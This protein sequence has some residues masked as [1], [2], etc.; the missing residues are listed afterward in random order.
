MI[1][2]DKLQKLTIKGQKDAEKKAAKEEIADKNYDKKLLEKLEQWLEY[3]ITEFAKGGKHKAILPISLG[4]TC[5]W[6]FK[7]LNVI[8]EVKKILNKFNFSDSDYSIDNPESECPV[9]I[10][11]W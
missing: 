1:T 5:R 4:R 11:K 7:H 2:K 8:E 6:P 9:I 10:I 3:M